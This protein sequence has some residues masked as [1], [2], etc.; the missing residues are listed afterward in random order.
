MTLFARWKL[1][2][3][4]LICGAAFLLPLGVLLYF[5]VSGF[6][7]QLRFTAREIAGA[8]ALQ[9]MCKLA[10]LL[11]GGQWDMIAA[12]ADSSLADIRKA[13]SELGPLLPP[14]SD[15][16]ARSLQVAALRPE[17]AKTA[18]NELLGQLYATFPHLAETA[19]LILDPDL[20]SYFLADLALLR[21]PSLHEPLSRDA[22]A[23][24]DP[25]QLKAA[26][27]AIDVV[28]E[29]NRLKHRVNRALETGLPRALAIFKA[30]P[31]GTQ[32]LEAASAL[33]Q[34]TVTQLSVLLDERAAALRR[35]RWM[36]L[37]LTLAAV[38][39]AAAMLFAVMRNVTVPLARATQ[40]ADRIA[41]GRLSAAEASL[42]E[43]G[44]QRFLGGPIMATNG[45][46]RDEAFRLL[47]AFCTMAK[48]LDSLVSEVRKAYADVEESTA[49]MA[50][51]LRQV[52]TSFAEQAASTSQVAASSKQIFATVTE[53]AKNMR[54]VTGMAAEA[55]QVANAGLSGLSGIN[56]AM[57]QTLEGAASVSEVLNRI[58]AK[59][60][61]INSVLDAITKIANRTNL[62][63]LNAAIEAEK[64]G[65][66]AAGFKAVGLEIRRVADQTAVAAL[67]IENMLGDMQSS[68]KEGVRSMAEYAER[69]RTNSETVTSIT[70]DVGR[71]IEC[72]RTLEPHFQTVDSGMQMQA[73]AAHEILEA[74]QQLSRAAGQSRESLAR[75]REIA[76]HVRSTVG[77]LQSEVAR[78]SV[79]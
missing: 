25:A 50:D 42:S 30:A 57:Q 78:F 75:F 76:D 66:H 62:I 46:I 36:A 2:H 40:V 39:F 61:D 38:A 41:E 28:V 59:A 12:G 68:V 53:L 37:T 14:S 74:I 33:W 63:S 44:L 64:A 16:A 10:V 45:H 8:R 69:L 5:T 20:D 1:A 67:E 56:A 26:E 18:R 15:A 51:A 79:T 52:E 23:A 54:S 6:Q 70:A 3:K 49:R 19:N 29:Q 77:V 27:H 34:T 13:E 22:S 9:P 72:T 48:S 17:E 43:P 7:Q 47:G 60:T 55:T 11:A 65:D 35:K 32:R 58:S 73:Q 24:P 31:P 21:V 71:S 4:L